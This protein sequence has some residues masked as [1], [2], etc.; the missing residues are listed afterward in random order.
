MKNDIIKPEKE[1]IVGETDSQLEEGAN[2]GSLAEKA[3]DSWTYIEDEDFPKIEEVK[4][5]AKY[6]I[7]HPEKEDKEL[8]R[9]QTYNIMYY[10]AFQLLN[11]QAE[12]MWLSQ[13]A[14][15]LYKGLRYEVVADLE[16]SNTNLTENDLYEEIVNIPEKESSKII[17][18]IKISDETKRALKNSIAAKEEEKF[19]AL[20]RNNPTINFKICCE[21]LKL[22]KFLTQLL[23]SIEKTF[24]NDNC[25][26]ALKLCKDAYKVCRDIKDDEGTKTFNTFY[27]AIVSE[28]FESSCEIKWSEFYANFFNIGAIIYNQYLG[29]NW[30]IFDEPIVEIPPMYRDKCEYCYNLW[31]KKNPDCN[32]LFSDESR[33]LT[34]EDVGIPEFEEFRK[35]YI[36][37]EYETAEEVDEDKSLENVADAI[38]EPSDAINK[39]TDDD[40]AHKEVEG[41]KNTDYEEFTL[42]DNL[43]DERVSKDSKNLWIEGIKCDKHD[44]SLPKHIAELINIFAE[45]DYI[46]D[47]LDTKE[48]FA[49]RLT[50]RKKP[51]HLVEKIK[52]YGENYTTLLYFIKKYSNKYGKYERFEKFLYLEIPFN[53]QKTDK[54]IAFRQYSSY[55]ET[56]PDVEL[57]EFID[58]NFS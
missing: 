57:K 13:T 34:I 10:I 16:E 21:F 27:K 28:G 37:E 40:T 35:K 25:E 50:G 36:P 39:E 56:C 58:E 49:F 19:T 30:E 5:S 48:T 23:N 8:N 42:P 24:S 7:L 4:E 38:D 53:D 29:N 9:T 14:A 54:K 45:N 31:K 20:I 12:K 22:K 46:D 15:Q 6:L 26:K 17:E 2:S 55:A 18:C 3:E 41:D 51:K 43:F 52:W 11:T 44:K 33:N 1:E 32:A 47:D